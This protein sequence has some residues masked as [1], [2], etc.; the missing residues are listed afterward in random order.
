M[1]LKEKR[2]LFTSLIIDLLAYIIEKGYKPMIG[3]DGMKHMANSLHFDGLAMDIDLNDK[4]GK[5]LSK[6]ED[7]TA[8]GIY[9]K[10]LHTGCRWG[11]DFKSK[12]GNHYSI[13]DLGRS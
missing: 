13:T 12:D 5:Y 4:A 10:T 8:F 2:I 11:G 1:T 9:W 3:R 7:H 6:T